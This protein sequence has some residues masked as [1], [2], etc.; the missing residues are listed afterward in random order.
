MNRVN[1]SVPSGAAVE[2][3]PCGDEGYLREAADATR[4]CAGR[5]LCWE[6]AASARGTVGVL[7]RALDS[8]KAFAKA[9]VRRI[10][11]SRQLSC[12]WL[13]PGLKHATHVAVVPVY[14]EA[15][16]L[17]GLLG[18]RRVHCCRQPFD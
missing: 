6:G 11:H 16:R 8:A 13:S 9:H 12:V 1:S 14:N 4:V 5:G 17:E 15:L 18:H 10:A 7:A 3:A 2:M